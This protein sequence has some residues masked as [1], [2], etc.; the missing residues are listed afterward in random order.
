MPPRTPLVETRQAL[1]GVFNKEK[2]EA[3]WTADQVNVSK[4]PGNCRSVWAVRFHISAFFIDLQM[5]L[6][7]LLKRYWLYSSLR[8]CGSVHWLFGCS[9]GNIRGKQQ[10]ARVYLGGRWPGDGGVIGCQRLGLKEWRHF[11][12]NL[13]W[14]SLSQTKFFIT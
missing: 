1:R 14:I 7:N 8:V 11:N 3:T 4:L 2:N 9:F 10:L 13:H 12:W 6:T 5:P